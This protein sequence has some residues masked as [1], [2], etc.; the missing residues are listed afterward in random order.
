MGQEPLFSQ[1]GMTVRSDGRVAGRT[2]ISR[3]V[4]T[5]GVILIY[6]WWNPS[7]IPFALGLSLFLDSKNAGMRNGYRSWLKGFA[8]F[9]LAALTA[10]GLF[11]YAVDPLWCFDNGFSWNS[12]QIVFNGRQQKTNQIT[13]AGFDYRTLLIGSSRTNCLNQND[14]GNLK[15]YNCAFDAMMPDEYPAYVSYAKKRNGKAFQTIYLGAD[16]FG[17]NA[18]LRREYEPPATY[19]GNANSPLYR[20]RMLLSSDAVGFSIDNIRHGMRKDSDLYDRSN[21]RTPRDTT[22][23]ERERII[24]EQL[25]WFQREGYGRNYRY[26]E[27][28]GK[29]LAG[30]R[31]ENPETRFIVFT[32]P[33]SQPLFCLLVREQRLP[34]YERWLRELVSVFGGFYHFMDLNSVTRNYLETFTDAHHVTP[35]AGRLITGRILGDGIIGREQPVVPADFGK[36]VT[37][38]NIDRIIAGVRA[39]CA[40]C[41]GSLPPLPENRSAIEAAGSE[42]SEKGTR[43]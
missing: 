3:F 42:A 20:Y 15:A 28:L 19:I 11:N 21:V 24:G 33:V 23:A 22:R 10:V 34:E 14:F 26:D 13:F 5:A 43:K 27:N 37:A 41:P 38:E 35:A 25:L 39:Q 8:W 30:L 18:N 7:F 31:R 17:T 36:L 16:F 40:A 9:L 1:S 2:L 32:T 4:R 6:V 12:R 29:K